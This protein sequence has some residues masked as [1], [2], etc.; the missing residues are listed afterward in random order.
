MAF[1]A[2]VHRYT[3]SSPASRWHSGVGGAVRNRPATY[4]G[5]M[6]YP[7][8]PAVHGHRPAAGSDSPVP[9]IRVGSAAFVSDIFDGVVARRMGIATPGL[10]HADTLVDTAFYVAAAVAMYV[11]VPRVFA[12][13]T[14]S[15][16]LTCDWG[17]AS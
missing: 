1:S 4:R 2:Q 16:D 3:G 7:Y 17:G 9:R 13:Q 8:D 6:P 14:L 5:V 15:R 10:R 11:A 12:G